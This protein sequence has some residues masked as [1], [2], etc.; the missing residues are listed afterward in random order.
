MPGKTCPRNDLLCVER[1]VKLYS[2]TCSLPCSNEYNIPL[3]C[4]SGDM[5]ALHSAEFDDICVNR[6]ADDDRMAHESQRFVLINISL[7]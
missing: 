6:A 2:L 3:F 4:H 5:A 7:L 1:D